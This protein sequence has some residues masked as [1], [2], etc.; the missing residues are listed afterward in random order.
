VFLR[1]V[2]WWHRRNVEAPSQNYFPSPRRAPAP[3]G[4]SSNLR[5]VLLSLLEGQPKHAYELMQLL[6]G[7]EGGTAKSLFPALQQLCDEGLVNV[8]AAFGWPTY[9]LSAAGSAE[10]EHK[11]ELQ[12]RICPWTVPRRN[13]RVSNRAM[14][15]NISRGVVEV[16]KAAVHSV[17]GASR[18][19][20][21]TSKV[22]SILERAKR[23]IEVL[24]KSP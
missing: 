8:D 9:Q 4:R 3:F 22:L 20:A 1:F 13:R 17:V 19:A 5:I 14:A 10:L 6:K 12:N 11:A 15:A 2:R 18:D 24:D 7:K 23:E 16:M 21:K